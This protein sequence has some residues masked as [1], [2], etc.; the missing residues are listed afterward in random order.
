MSNLSYGAAS[1]SEFLRASLGWP[2]PE[3]ARLYTHR[4]PRYI[5]S[6]T[7]LDPDNSKVDKTELRH[8][9]LS[10]LY[11]ISSVEVPTHA[12]AQDNHASILSHALQGWHVVMGI[13]FGYIFEDDGRLSTAHVILEKLTEL[14]C[15]MYAM[16]VA[17][18]CGIGPAMLMIIVSCTLLSNDTLADQSP[19]SGAKGPDIKILWWWHT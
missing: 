14:L 3:A 12:L 2:V 16:A 6:I 8:R 4:L 19:A 11:E 15:S 1:K 17:K 18:G 9:F 13:Q 7:L 10:L 5:A